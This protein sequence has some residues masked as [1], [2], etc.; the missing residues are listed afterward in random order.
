MKSLIDRINATCLAARSRQGRKPRK[1]SILHRLPPE[2]RAKVDRWLFDKNLTYAQVAEG[3]WK[4]FGVKVSQSS[5]GRYYQ[6]FAHVPHAKTKEMLAIE[7]LGPLDPETGYQLL[8]GRLLK[9]AKD[10]ADRIEFGLRFPEYGVERC[11]VRE[12]IRFMRLLIAARR[13][14]TDADM[15]RLE[16][17]KFEIGAAKA[18]LNHWRSAIG[19]RRW[20]A[21]APGTNLPSPASGNQRRSR[22]S[23]HRARDEEHGLRLPPRQN[24][25]CSPKLKK[26]CDWPSTH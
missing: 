20:A 10:A 26:Q 4:M 1:D 5:V 14:R 12:S 8:L 9:L 11:E 23:R 21:K 16:R 6:S 15:A 7:D 19:Y 3:C 17:D 13:E 25:P 22:D 24:P 18:C 2:Q